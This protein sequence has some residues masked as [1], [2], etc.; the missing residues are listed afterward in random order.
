MFAIPALA[1]SAPRGRG[2]ASSRPA[3][4][5]I[6]SHESALVPAP[7]RA[8]SYGAA[9]ESERASLERIREFLTR[10][11]D[12]FSRSNPEGHVTASAVVARRGDAAFL[13]VWHLKLDRWLQPCGHLEPSDASVFA[14]AL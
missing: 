9:G 10:S 2:A 6:E 8:K 1:G 3:G 5:S 14:A 7:W 11:P 12:P 13:L 4:D